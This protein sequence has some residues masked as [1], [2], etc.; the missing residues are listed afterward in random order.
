MFDVGQEVVCI[1][2]GDIK[3]L[4]KNRH[5]TISWIGVV[6]LPRF[7]DILCVR[8][9]GVAR[10]VPPDIIQQVSALDD[11]ILLLEPSHVR[12]DASLKDLPF[13]ATRFAP[14]EKKTTDISE[15]TK[16]LVSTERVLEDA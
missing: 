8:L 5:Y 10:M 13:R 2:P 7:K 12:F 1:E 14:I 16:L 11:L 4:V 15:L 3:E 6:D 9:V